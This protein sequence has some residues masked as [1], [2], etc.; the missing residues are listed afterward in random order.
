MQMCFRTAAYRPEESLS[1]QE[2]DPGR[3]R[4]S[5]AQHRYTF[6]R[7]ILISVVLVLKDR[8]DRVTADHKWTRFSTWTAHDDSA[9]IRRSLVCSARERLKLGQRIIRRSK[10]K[11]NAER[12][13]PGSRANIPAISVLVFQRSEVSLLHPENIRH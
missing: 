4:R 2:L 12:G 8:T 1:Q 5:F 9:V 7:S 11:T 6:P 3:T 10:E 13:D